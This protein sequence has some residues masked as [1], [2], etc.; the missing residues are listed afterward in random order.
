MRLRL[1]ATTIIMAS[2]VG[3]KRK[4]SGTEV[5]EAAAPGSASSPQ[6]EKRPRAEEAGAKVE[7]ETGGGAE[8][9]VVAVVAEEGDC[10]GSELAKWSGKANL[11]PVKDL[12]LRHGSKI[13]V[14]WDVSAPEG[15][16]SLDRVWWGGV[17]VGE[18]TSVKGEREGEEKD[19][20]GLSSKWL[21]KYQKYGSFEEETR[22]V[23]FL[24][25]H[26]LLDLA[27]KQLL[28][29]REEGDNYEPPEV[30][31]QDEVVTLG[32]MTTE[33]IRDEDMAEGLAELTKLPFHKQQVFASEYR[34]MADTFKQ[35]LREILSSKGEG[36]VVD[37]DDIHRITEGIRNQ[38]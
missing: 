21:L 19:G 22:T 35:K 27:E 37:A 20:F 11:H 4:L 30:L 33:V 38:S 1:R 26:L 34:Q 10:E 12:G 2:S 15:D 18:A 36:Y 24:E 13:E 32:D 8:G 6:E 5:P 16:H 3:E 31:P 7:D 28:E 25:S 29:W 9:G 14:L 23:V 17:L